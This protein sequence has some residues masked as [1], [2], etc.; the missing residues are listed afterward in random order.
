[1]QLIYD[2]IEPQ[3][4]LDYVRTYDNEVLR[5]DNQFSLGTDYFPAVL[6]EDLEFRIRK[7]AL[8]DV[9][10][11]MFR[12]FDTPAPMTDRPGTTTMYGSLGPVSRQIPLGEEEMLR[13]RSLEQ[14][15]ND[16]IIQAILDDAE[17]MIRAVQARLELACGD[18]LDDGK[19]TLDENGLQIEADFGRPSTLTKTAT[20]SHDD[21]DDALVITDLL[22][23]Q[24]AFSDENGEDPDHILAP[25]SVVGQ[26]LLN[27]EVRTYGIGGNGVT[28]N[29]LTR[30]DLDSVFLAEGLPPVRYYDVTVRVDGVKTR[31]LPEEKIFFMGSGAAGARHYGVTAEAIKLRTKGYI[32]KEAAPG[33]VAV[34]VENDHPVQTWTVGTALSLPSINP[35]KVLDAEVLN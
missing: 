2:L 35:Y 13:T 10:V 27:E 21:A 16:P 11:A 26:W 29:R 33:I 17:R 4:L 3:V 19:V 18:I 34:V 30:S 22:A 28:P 9:D 23:W 5:P 6:T 7:G 1:M 15:T 20:T 8:N 24:K 25:R 32:K 31:V 12:A 14:N